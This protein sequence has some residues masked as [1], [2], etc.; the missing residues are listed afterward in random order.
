[1]R[2]SLIAAMDRKRL[3]GRDNA[4]P[5]Y[6]PA[7]LAHF[8]ATTLG[9]PILMGR[10]TFESLGRPLPGRLNIV[11]S[12]DQGY[13]ADGITV[14]HDLD[15]AFAAAGDVPELMV[16][17]GATLYE[18]LLPRIERMYLTFIDAEFD[19]DA[20]FPAWDADEWR[21]SLRD[22]HP[23]DTKNPYPYSF[24]QLDRVN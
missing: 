8:K 22:A 13:N 15:E 10:K 17:G 4:M 6:L 5:W 1:M 24:V 3:I 9:K 14:V 18:T 11:L 19:G 20:W 7:A 2:L 16:I 23:G 12:R 21:E